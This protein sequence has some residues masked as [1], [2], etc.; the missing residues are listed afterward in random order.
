MSALDAVKC[1]TCAGIQD[2]P[3][4]AVGYTCT[5][6]CSDWQWAVCLGCA[7]LELALAG[8]ESWRCTRCS[9]YTRSWWR[10]TTAD[11]EGRCVAALRLGRRLERTR[12]RD[13]APRRRRRRAAA[14]ATGSAVVVLAA[15]ALLTAVGGASTEDHDRAACA[16]FG[17]ARSTIANGGLRDDEISRALA[18]VRAEAVQGSPAIT[19]AVEQLVAAG[20]PGTAAFLVAQTRVVRVCG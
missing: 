11:Q 14:M 3:A 18:G 8:Q 12:A 17:D 13:V 5:L 1:P 15:A 4:T 6:C 2:V 19:A 16:A 20:R 7:R 9:R 10:S